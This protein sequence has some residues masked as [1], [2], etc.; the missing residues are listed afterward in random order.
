MW[1]QERDTPRIRAAF[2]T[3]AMTRESWPAPRHFIDALPRVAQPLALEKG[4]KPASP[5]AVARARAQ[6]E[7]FLADPNPQPEP[8]PE[9]RGPALTAAEAALR[10]HYGRDR[11]TAAAGPDA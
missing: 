6:V 2:S 4:F 5:E 7:S 8:E 9:S 11:K 3:L 1:N 10:E